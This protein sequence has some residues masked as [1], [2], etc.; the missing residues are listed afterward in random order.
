[1]DLLEC[2]KLKQSMYVW[3]SN[4]LFIGK[5]IDISAHKHHNVQIS[6][7]LDNSF[8][9]LANNAWKE[10]SAVI[11]D[12][13]QLHQFDGGDDW[14]LYILMDA[15]TEQCRHLRRELLAHNKICEFSINRK[16]IINWLFKLINGENY[17]TVKETF[18]KI[19]SCIL[20]IENKLKPIEPR[21]ENVI[22]NIH[23]MSEKDISVRSLSSLV[24]LSESRLI[25]LFKEQVGIPIRSYILWL[26][27]IKAVKHIMNGTTFTD[28][29]YQTGFTDSAHLCHVFRQMFGLK[30]SDLFKNSKHVQLF[31]YPE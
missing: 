23:Q 9:L 22:N 3:K 24:Y 16:E 25:H 27:I 19:L 14:Q 2:S 8:K 17:F 4:M 26:R 30:L 31:I 12:K 18:D 10:Y 29:A 15:E 7:G 5:S 11:I 6:I 28:A 21:I 13:D 20:P 1:M